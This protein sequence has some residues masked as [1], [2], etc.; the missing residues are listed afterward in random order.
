MAAA[1]AA[2][3]WMTWGAPLLTLKVVPS[4]ALHSRLG[5]L[6]HR[7]ERL[8]MLILNGFNAALSFNP[9]RTARSIVSS[10]SDREANAAARMS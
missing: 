7:I 3:A 5:A 2:N 8:E 1:F 9:A 4:A 10:F 6:V